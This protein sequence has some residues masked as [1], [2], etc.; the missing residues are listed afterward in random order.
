MAETSDVYKWKMRVFL[1]ESR[2]TTHYIM[3]PSRYV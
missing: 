2:A 1:C 3:S